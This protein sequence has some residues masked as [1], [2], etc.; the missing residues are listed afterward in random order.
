VSR[1]DDIVRTPEQARAQQRPPLLVLDPL[2]RF[3]DA[4]G[5][6]TGPLSAAPIG[7][8]HSNPTFALRRGEDRFV[9]RRPPRPPLP[10]S[11]HDVLREHR[12]TAALAGTDVRVPAPLA[13]CAD[14]AVIGAPF[15][16]M[17]HLDGV[18]LATA[19]PEA[20]DDPAMRG[21]VADELIDAL[22]QL[23]LADWRRAGLGDFGRPDGFLERQVRR[24]T[25]LWTRNRT[26][27]VAVVDEV[28]RRLAAAV[29]VTQRASI[30]HGDYRLGNVMY[31]PAPP[32]RL[33]AIVDWE[34]ATVGD[35]L[36]DVGY[37]LSSYLEPGED[38]GV[39][40]AISSLT[41][42]DGFPSRARLV[43]RY[44][45]AT[46]LRADGI[47]WYQALAHFKLAVILEGSYRR[48]LAG[49][50]DDPWLHDMGE[51]VPQLAERALAVLTAG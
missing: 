50:T 25:D 51:A 3:L 36:T 18:V 28:G 4:H 9:L 15:Y 38:P 24:F 7:D 26:R 21:A 14:A 19:I 42:R 43:A 10:P 46:G 49:S 29:P 16:V 37:L 8:G 17:E 45:A 41:Q 20:L 35:P 40:G 6:G 1:D 31:A 27:E 32:A 11:A 2:E 30:V 39:L 44:E 5:L 48:L 23:H 34:L 47:A 33:I 13:A 12:V 22:A